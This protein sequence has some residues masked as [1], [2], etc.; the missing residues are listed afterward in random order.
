MSQS[1]RPR[2]RAVPLE[3]MDPLQ[4]QGLAPSALATAIGGWRGVLDS[5]LPAVLFVLVYTRLG[6][7]PAVYAALGLAAVLLVVR[8]LR[9]EPV[10]YAANGFAGVAISTL[11]ALWLG[12][13][14]GY[15]LPGIIVNAVYAAVFLISVAVRRPLVGLVIKALSPADA[16]GPVDG[17]VARVHMWATVGWAAVFATRAGVQGALYLAGRPGWLATAKLALGWPLTLLALAATVAAV[18]RVRPA[19]PVEAAPE[20]PPVPLS[21]GRP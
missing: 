13:A 6:L 2:A 17:R 5:S 11:F 4:P 8:L 16:A 15:F 19:A 9:R 20:G 12:R 10:R 1:G 3:C 7:R 21:G 18:R 14:E